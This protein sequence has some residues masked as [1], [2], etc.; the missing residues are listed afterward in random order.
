[1]PD[2]VAASGCYGRNKDAFLEGALGSAYTGPALGCLSASSMLEDIA[3]VFLQIRRFGMSM[4][5]KISD[6]SHVVKAEDDQD[7]VRSAATMACNRAIGSVP[8]GIPS[9]GKQANL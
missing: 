9:F 3:N 6:S 8:F 7:S 5:A 4:A 1:M 2:Y